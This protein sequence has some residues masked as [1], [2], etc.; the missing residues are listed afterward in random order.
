MSKKTTK[1]DC[2]HKTNRYNTANIETQHWTHIINNF[3]TFHPYYLAP[4]VHLNDMLPSCE[5]TPSWVVS[6]SNNLVLHGYHPGCMSAYPI[7][8]F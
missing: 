1:C 6:H 4:T 7:T 2:L 3:S 8:V 5:I